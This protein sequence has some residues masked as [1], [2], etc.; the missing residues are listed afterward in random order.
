MNVGALRTS[1]HGALRRIVAGPF[2]RWKLYIQSVLVDA[3]LAFAA[4]L[5]SLRLA[6]NLVRRF[7]DRRAPEFAAWAA[8][9]AAYAMAGAALAWG[10]AAG[11]SD[12]AYRAYYLGG[13]LLTAALLGTG[14]LLLTG[15]RRWIVPVALVY[16]GL[17][18][19]IALAVPLHGNIS[20]TTIPEAQDV[21]DLW[22][23]RVAAIAGNSL[24]TLAV[25]VV[26]LGTF[27]ARPLGNALI[28]GG[29]GVAAVGSGLAGLG[30]GAM[31]PAI[32]V[33]AVLLY[34]GFVIPT[35]STTPRR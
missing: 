24:G 17:A 5:L 9:L 35:K 27:R 15:R 1:D 31:A 30:V 7:R 2:S 28:L 13:G 11:W 33:A 14:S 12:A 16:A 34:M 8:A 10:A 32:A 29:V 26:G 23:A 25:V 21:L 6:G 20:G 18:T 22:P 4:A 19:G 3:L